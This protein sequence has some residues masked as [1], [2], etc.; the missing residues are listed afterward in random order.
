MPRWLWIHGWGMSPS[1]WGPWPQ[2]FPDIEHHVAS[3]ADCH[4]PMDLKEAVR[5]KL[6]AHPGPWTVVGWSLG[7]M[8]A[9]EVVS[10]YIIWQKVSGI[11]IVAGS[12]QFVHPDRSLGT[13]KPLLTAMIRSLQRDP[14][15]T[16][17]QFH[18][19]VFAQWPEPL[20][21]YP[22]ISDSDF[23]AEGLLAGLHYLAEVDVRAHWEKVASRALW[24]HGEEDP[25]CPVGGAPKQAIVLPGVGHAPFLA[26]PER[27][28]MEMKR[29]NE[30]NVT[31][32]KHK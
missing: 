22:N 31:S 27:V 6:T 24:I 29:W 23:T 19:K 16:L 11:I 26:S 4:T 3:F 28:T 32:T 1:I 8:L 5:S 9:I 18:A 17:A 25:I 7:A 30:A 14:I 20:R 13:P 10:E 2:M 21:E 15:N 12:L